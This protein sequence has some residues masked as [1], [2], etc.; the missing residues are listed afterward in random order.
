MARLV[1]LLLR[2]APCAGRRDLVRPGARRCSRR[3]ARDRHGRHGVGARPR[4]WSR[5]CSRS[6]PPGRSSTSAPPRPQAATSRPHPTAP[7][8]STTPRAARCSTSPARPR[9]VCARRSRLSTSAVGPDGTLWLADRTQLLHLSPAELS[10]APCDTAD[11]ELSVPGAAHDRVSLR[12]L[13]RA[14]G[15][16]VRSNETA[17]VSGYIRL[18]GT[19]RKVGVVDGAIGTNGVVVTFSKTT[20]D[21]LAR[22]AR[23]RQ[24]NAPGP[25]AHAHRRQRQRRG[26][27][28]HHRGDGLEHGIE[29]V[30][31]GS[32]M[33]RR[34][35]A[36][37]GPAASPDACSALASQ[38]RWQS[39]PWWACPTRRPS[40]RRGSTPCP[41]SATC[42]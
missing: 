13:R 1:R 20:L 12:A 11:P 39:W 32:R 24:A 33:Q 34:S 9:R 40:A 6:R 29:V 36:G 14:R 23:G 26:Q 5:A 4:R 21:L 30:P 16:R 18:V 42:S 3:C 41:A 17:T 22:A 19:K 35:G 37:H 31:Q 25:P 27:P 28:S 15:L 38:R 7:R 2:P 8:R 10:T